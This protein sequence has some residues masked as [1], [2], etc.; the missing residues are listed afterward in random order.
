MTAPCLRLSALLL[1]LVLPAAAL[2]QMPDASQMHGLAIPA[3]ELATGTVTVRVVRES[4]GNNLPGQQVRVTI[5][6]TTRTATTDDQGRA[7]FPNLTP[8]ATGVAEAVVDGE[9]LTSRPF[10]VPAAGGLRVILVAGLTQAGRGQQPPP[11]AA[12]TAPAEK[13]AVVLGA[14]TRVVMEFRDDRLQVFYILDIVNSATTPVDIGGPL[15]LQLPTG[16][17]GAATMEGSSPSA[18]VSGDVVTVQGPFAPG[19]T[20]VQVAFVLN[21]SRADVMLEQQWPVALERVSVAAERVGDLRLSSPQ[22]ENVNEVRAE[23]GSPY[24]LASGPALAAGSTMRIVLEGLPV[25]S[26]V[27]RYVG[28]GIA[29]AILAFG[30]WLAFSGRS[31]DT[32]ARRRLM[33][34]RDTLMGEVA[35]LEARR[36][37]GT[38]DARGAARQQKLLAELEQIYG[39]LDDASTG[40]QGGGEGIAA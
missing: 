28:I 10:Q 1:A 24:V 39:E 32:D 40:P 37:A 12:A 21:Y 31:R 36:R 9:T 29:G 11:S 35:Q 3:G 30:A 4:L 33:H 27:P 17:A 6:G 14:G 34:R 20:S 26:S 7:E 19:S 13:G 23:D 15:I 38:L 16:A 2:A 5:D 25:H 8:A 18:T 22:F